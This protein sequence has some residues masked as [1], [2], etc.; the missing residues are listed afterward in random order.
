MRFRK[1]PEIIEA[2]QF[3]GGLISVEQIIEEL[4]IPEKSYNFKNGADGGLYIHT[5]EG[6]HIVKVG[7]WVIK[8]STGFYPLS[9]SVFNLIYEPVE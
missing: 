2:E 9:Q 4:D 5:I 6:T 7:D 3:L 1:K 8:T